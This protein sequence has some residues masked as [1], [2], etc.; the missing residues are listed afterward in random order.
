MDE[1][2]ACIGCNAFIPSGK[3][4]TGQLLINL[5]VSFLGVRASHR[6]VEESLRLFFSTLRIP[7]VSCENLS[8]NSGEFICLL[9][10]GLPC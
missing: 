3:I 2:C 9:G 8:D 10:L 4:L 5:F 1:G 6:L 7:I